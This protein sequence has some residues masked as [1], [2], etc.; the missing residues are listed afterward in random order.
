VRVNAIEVGS[1][2]TSALE[3]VAGNEEMKASMEARTP[4][5]RLGEVED[6]A[7]A[8]VYL[9]TPAAGWV[10]GKV[11]QVDGGT[12]HPQLDVPVEPL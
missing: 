7:A 4:M 11:L 2:L 8:V 10:T 9:A 1:V 3:Y 6:I 5:G 12:E